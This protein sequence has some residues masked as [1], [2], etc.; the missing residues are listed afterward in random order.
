M[1]LSDYNKHVLLPEKQFEG[2]QRPEPFLTRPASQHAEW[3]E[4]CKTGSPTGSNFEYAGWLTETNHLGNVA[5][6]AGK[7]LQWD[8][9]NL[10]A[11][12][13]PEAQPF[14]QREYR[15]GWKLV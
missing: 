6:R 3:I 14:I 11:T 4:A 8:P 7:K 13:C 2:F 9:V 15:S 10:R 12:N 1:L 5:Y